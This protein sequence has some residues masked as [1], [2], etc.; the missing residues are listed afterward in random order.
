M[1]WR[2]KYKERPRDIEREQREGRT[3]AARCVAG[4][5]ISD[6]KVLLAKRSQLRWFHPDVWDLFGGP[7]E[8]EESAEDALRREAFEELQVEIESFRLLDTVHDPVEPADIMVFAISAWKG[9]PINAAPEEHSRIGWV[10]VGELP[11]SA[12][13]DVYGGLIVQPT[14][15]N[16]DD[17]SC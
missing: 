11:N 12:V 5:L 10:P 14:A 8:G 13:L 6:G 9:E 4:A 1:L 17:S 2:G 16:P 15:M 7:V 3:S